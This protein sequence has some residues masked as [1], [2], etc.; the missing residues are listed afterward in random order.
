[1]RMRT[2][3]TDLDSILDTRLAVLYKEFGQDIEKIMPNYKDRQINSFL[4]L[5]DNKGFLELYAKRDIDVLRDSIKTESFNILR[6][7]VMRVMTEMSMS[8]TPSPPKIILNVFPYELDQNTLKTLIN[9]IITFVGEFVDVEVI[10]KPECEITPKY[11]DDEIELYLKY[12]F[13]SW[14]DEQARLFTFKKYKCPDVI[15]MTAG[16][17]NMEEETYNA[18]LNDEQAKVLSPTESISLLCISLINI[19]FA[20]TS[21]FSCG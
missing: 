7:F 2:L 16:V 19:Q 3:L 4:P 5:V 10:N 20:A 21:L 12:D 8:P 14:L 6:S 17:L 15:M 18:L 11:L 1:M 9:L 13:S